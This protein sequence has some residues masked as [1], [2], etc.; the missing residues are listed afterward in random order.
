MPEALRRAFSST[1]AG[2][3]LRPGTAVVPVTRRAVQCHPPWVDRGSDSVPGVT[4]GL[5]FKRWV[6]AELLEHDH[7]Q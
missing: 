2:H 3:G 5:R 6:L 7:G 4:V 1:L